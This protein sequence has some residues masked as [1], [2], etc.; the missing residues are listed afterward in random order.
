MSEPEEIDLYDA[1]HTLNELLDEA[2]EHVVK[3]RRLIE[4]V[5]EVV[6]AFGD[7]VPEEI[8][9]AYKAM[10]AAKDSV[11]QAIAADADYQQRELEIDTLENLKGIADIISE[12]AG[13][14]VHV[15]DNKGSMATSH[16][17]EC[18]RTGDGVPALH[19]LAAKIPDDLVANIAKLKRTD[20][21]LVMTF[22]THLRDHVRVDAARRPFAECV[23]TACIGGFHYT[24]QEAFFMTSDDTPKLGEAHRAREVS[25]IEMSDT[26]D[27]KLHE[28]WYET[29]N[30][31]VQSVAYCPPDPK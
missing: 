10:T 28:K 29:V 11:K 7:D 4:I 19:S 5:D 30:V 25:H 23:L 21:T 14:I 3:K 13:Y 8:D 6:T 9:V 24:E 20:C 17:I 27:G 15:P 18:I 2:E 16:L 31:I 1:I 26:E 22:R 12:G